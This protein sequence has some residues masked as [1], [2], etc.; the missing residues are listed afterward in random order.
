MSCSTCFVTGSG[1]SAPAGLPRQS[2]L[3]KYLA[4]DKQSREILTAIFNLKKDADED[5]LTDLQLE[6]IFTFLDTIIAANRSV[7]IHEPDNDMDISKSALIGIKEA[8]DYKN[9]LIECIINDVAKTLQE[10]RGQHRY[11]HFCNSIVDRKLHRG[12][13]NTI[14]TLNW[15]TIPDF[16]INK[17]CKDSGKEK[18][19]VDYGIYDWDA[20]T[21]DDAYSN[22]VPSILRK[23][24]GWSTV[25]LLKLHGSM[26]WALSKKDN[27][28]YI[29]QQI[30]AYPGRL[31]IDKN[32]K[33]HFDRV[34]MTPTFIKN[35]GNMHTQTIW[36]NAAFDLTEAQRVVFIG[37][38]LQTADYEFR[39][40]LLRTAVR[41]SR[42]KIRVI[43][44]PN[45]H[46]VEKERIRRRYQTLFAG[47]G[48]KN[49]QFEEIDTSDFLLDDDF[50][51]HW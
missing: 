7:I 35:L 36:H 10:L 2:G 17:A 42:N 11:E 4:A 50:I 26:N 13:T 43:I 25:K 29:K 48:S 34:F 6:D 19:G 14:I 31:D 8:Y 33:K 15:D 39:N 44:Y 21:V 38:A 22:Y 41:N 1:F 40:L 20:D 30:G 47:R 32:L 23:A 3:L 46:P 5:I 28:L 24:K 27:A 45:E 18:G 49:L 37:C 51:W 12:E 16:Y 9:T